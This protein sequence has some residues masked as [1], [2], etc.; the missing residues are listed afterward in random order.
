MSSLI[1]IKPQILYA[2]MLASFGGG[3][4]RG[5][6]RG[7]GGGGGLDW[8]F[9]FRGD[10]AVFP[11][12]YGKS[13][14]ELRPY[15]TAAP[16]YNDTSLFNVTTLGY[17]DVLITTAGNYTITATGGSNNKANSASGGAKGYG[18]V[19]EATFTLAENSALRIIVGSSSENTSG[20]GGS[21]V[22]YKQPG[23]FTADPLNAQIGL[24]SLS[25]INNHLLIAAGG[26]GGMQSAGGSSLD[27]T[28]S[29]GA[30]PT[31][32]GAGQQSGG[33]DQ[34]EGVNGA[35]GSYVGSDW[36]GAGGAGI[37]GHGTQA[38][39][40]GSA[41]SSYPVKYA[42]GFVA[43]ARSG[44]YGQGIA[45]FGG[46]AAGSYGGSGGGGY[47]GGSADY[48]NG[49]GGSQHSGG[50]GG[51]KVGTS[52]LAAPYVGGSTYSLSS[53]GNGSVYI[54]PA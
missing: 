27:S 45:G 42:D 47:S 19:V 7:T 22:F 16:F 31:F 29:N 24:N 25:D 17:Q 4:S 21:F 28:S 14:A 1:K 35:G 36:S 11:S 6:G 33:G 51:S 2:P 5:F 3:S 52:G 23:A 37:T 38:Y 40:G 50:G 12:Q 34:Y 43:A 54:R 49:S 8:T 32:N 44:S 15:Q 53:G 46:G 18:A 41:A 30:Q 10:S 26:A 20:A 39:E 13:Y 48:S 9:V